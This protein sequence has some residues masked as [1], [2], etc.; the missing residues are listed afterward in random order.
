MLQTASTTSSW[1][2]CFIDLCESTFRE[3][4][5]PPPPVAFEAGEAVSM[6]FALDDLAFE[7]V[8]A[9]D[10]RPDQLLAI[11]RFEPPG[12]TSVAAGLA[13]LMAVNRELLRSGASLGAMG[14]E[15][16]LAYCVRRDLMRLDAQGIFALSADMATQV[17]AWQAWLAATPVATPPFAPMSNLPLAPFTTAEGEE[18]SDFVTQL[19]RRT[20]SELLSA[21]FD[22]LGE[23][24]AEFRRGQVDFRICTLP[25]AQ[26]NVRLDCTFGDLPSDS[27]GEQAALSR[28]LQI[29]RAISDVSAEAGFMVDPI[30]HQARFERWHS[31]DAKAIDE[32][33]EA[34]TTLTN[35]A[36][37][38]RVHFYMEEDAFTPPPRDLVHAFF[39]A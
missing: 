33:A 37:A 35:E 39:L 30:S 22:G 14:S 17:Q 34:V 21:S 29:N 27:A 2:S 28:L 31:L 9:A 1:R 6:A 11:C 24:H 36:E 25:G 26:G 38:W 5:F 20:G 13:A 19:C 12:A 18:F 15:G 7:I 16:L 23:A 10:E 8:H 32:F 3:F 4:G